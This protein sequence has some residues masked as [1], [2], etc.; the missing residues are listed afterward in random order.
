MTFCKVLATAQRDDDTITAYECID[1]YSSAARY[2]IA[3]SKNGIARLVFHT[4]RTTWKKKFKELA[5][6]D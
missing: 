6:I 1:K 3:V 2:E 4:A 5:A